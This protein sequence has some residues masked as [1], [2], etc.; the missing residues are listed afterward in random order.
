MNGAAAAV[1]RKSWHFGRWIPQL[2]F[3][4]LCIPHFCWSS[5]AFFFFLIF[6]R[7][8]Q[9]CKIVQNFTFRNPLLTSVHIQ[10]VVKLFLFSGIRKTRTNPLPTPKPH[11]FP[12][13]MNSLI[14]LGKTS[15]NGY[16]LTVRSTYFTAPAVNFFF[17][18]SRIWPGRVRWQIQEEKTV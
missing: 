2:P 1:A 11:F 13:G 10:W 16:V 15:G 8:R 14:L 17:G 4:L 12:F 6:F 7:N 5:K 3:P 9:N 18:I